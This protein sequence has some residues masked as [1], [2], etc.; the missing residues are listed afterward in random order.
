MVDEP[1]K[2]GEPPQRAG[3]EIPGTASGTHEPPRR[4]GLDLSGIPTHQKP[5]VDPQQVSRVAAETGFTSRLAREPANVAD[6]EMPPPRRRPKRAV[7]MVQFNGRVRVDVLRRI[8]VY[9]EDR[10]IT[11][12][13]FLEAAID[14]LEASSSDPVVR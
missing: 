3:L 2:S 1:N 5:R 8:H 6:L 13:E 11:N 4:T 12:G 9:C 7:P 14:A 10:R